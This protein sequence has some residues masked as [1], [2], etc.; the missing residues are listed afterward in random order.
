ME[1]TLNELINELC[2]DGVESKELGDCIAYEQP[3]KYLVK[4]KDYSPAFA[5]P[6]L[7]AGKTFIL[8]YTD[9]TDGIYNASVNNPV[10]IFDDFT[11]SSKLVTFPFKA[12]SS[13]MKMLTSSNPE[14]FNIRYFFYV[15]QSL[16]FETHDHARQ[17]IAKYSQQEVPVPPLPVQEEIVRILDTMSTLTAEK[18]A[19]K[20][21][22]AYYRGFLLSFDN[23]HPMRE[24]LQEHCQ[25]GVEYKKIQDLLITVS[26]NGK[27][28]HTKKALSTG[29][30]PVIDQGAKG[31]QGFSDN[32]DNVIFNEDPI[33]AYGDHTTIVK[34]LD[35]PFVVGGDGLKTF[36]VV[37]GNSPKYVYYLMTFFNVPQ[38][39]YKRHFIKMRDISV[40][41]PPLSVQ[42]EIVS[43]LDKL[44]DLAEGVDIGLPREI[45][46]AQ[47]QYDYYLAKLLDFPEA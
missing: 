45:E 11:T 19:R 40:P 29:A 28:I 47:K 44:S 10:I 9:E 7:T 27:K 33:I 34:Y 37:G 20:K 42:E 22:Y 1:K 17:W 24:A 30:F 36:T 43:I 16:K 23:K 2:P 46:L 21:Q 32:R 39:G 35:F 6:V 25:D 14:K 3:T 8:G 31:I 26:Q 12:K 5:T 41:V 13:A 4:T 18:E 15:M 38:D